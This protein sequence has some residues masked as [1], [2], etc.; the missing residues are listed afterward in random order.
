MKAARRQGGKAAR[1]RID[2]RPS[3]QSSVLSRRFLAALPPCRLAAFRR[4]P[5]LTIGLAIILTL[6]TLALAAPLL[7]PAPPNKINA[8]AALQGVSAAHP[9]G[10]DNL[11]RDILSRVLYGYRLSLTIAFAATAASLAVG[12]PLGLIAGYAGRWTDNVI[13]RI[14]DVFFAFPTILLAIALIAVFGSGTGVLILAIG[15]VY[16]PY[17][18]RVVRGS[19]LALK[20]ELFVEGAR[21]R[22]AE[23]LRLMFRHILPNLLGAILVQVSLLLGFA[24][25]IEAALSFLGLGTEPPTPS[26]GR[27][28]ADGRDFMSQNPPVVVF[29]GLAI[30][31][32]VL[33]FNL[34]GDGIRDWADPRK[35]SR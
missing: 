27:M 3:T 11:G 30:A 31:I 21:A 1:T 2:G 13:M 24:I 4:Y 33:S 32:A 35:R 26:L 16:V 5:S 25:L 18:A 17:I 29:P 7:A 12:V 6:I 14:L 9:F 10:T 22:G 8:K 15:T 19:T 28:L 34:I 23:P 20:G